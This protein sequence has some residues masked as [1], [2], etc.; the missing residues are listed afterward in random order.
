MTRYISLNFSYAQKSFMYVA[1]ALTPLLR[2][3]T[4]SCI[5]THI[6]KISQFPILVA[7]HQAEVCDPQVENRLFNGSW[8]QPMAMAT[9]AAAVQT[10]FSVEH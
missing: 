6:N 1:E 3:G 7:A 8:F 2:L 5:V 9:H 10:D 4:F